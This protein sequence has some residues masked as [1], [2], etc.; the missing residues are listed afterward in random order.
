MPRHPVPT[1]GIGGPRN[2]RT[3]V[4]APKTLFAVWLGVVAGH[5]PKDARADGFGGQP[6]W[7]LASRASIAVMAVDTVL[8]TGT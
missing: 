3:T 7:L 5:G 4:R 2:R 6:A 8:W 1:K